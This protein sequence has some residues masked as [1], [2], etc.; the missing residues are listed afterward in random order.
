MYKRQEYSTSVTSSSLDMSTLGSVITQYLGFMTVIYVLL[1]I[2]MWKIF[3]KAGK[4]GWASIVPI[5]NVIVMFQIIGLNPWLLLLY[6]IPVVNFVVAIVFS[7]MQASRLS[8]AFGKGTGFAFGLFFLNPIFLLI[9]G[10]G[11][12]KYIGIQK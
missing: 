11:D 10:F 4:P 7:I 12:S 8:K 1:I 5:Y 3:T 9:L 6:L 2:A